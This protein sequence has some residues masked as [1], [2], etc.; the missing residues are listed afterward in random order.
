[1]FQVLG[2]WSY[3]IASKSFPLPPSEC[4]AAIGYEHAT[5]DMVPLLVPGDHFKAIGVPRAGDWLHE[6]KEPSQSYA[7][8]RDSE[9]NRVTLSRRTIYV[10]PIGSMSDNN[11]PSLTIISDFI[12]IWFVLPCQ[13]MQPYTIDAH[14]KWPVASTSKVKQTINSTAP[15]SSSSSSSESK[16]KSNFSIGAR[17]NN[18]VISY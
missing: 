13:L 5:R 8:Y 12:A 17:I 3:T 18:G 9:Y 7:E 10:V 6:H 1:M 4:I 11:S 2:C 14:Q 15:G 16:A